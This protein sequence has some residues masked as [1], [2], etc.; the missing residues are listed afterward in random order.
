MSTDETNLTDYRLNM[1]EKTLASISESL[2]QLTTLE[3]KHIETRE[4]MGRAFDTIRDQDDR[5][6][7]I[8]AEIP[9]MKLVRGWVV[10]GMV[11]T[12]GLSGVALFKLIVH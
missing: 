2:R 4:A 3:Q 9:T 8:E 11:G 10:A 5:L 12:C 1:I 7:V 6:R